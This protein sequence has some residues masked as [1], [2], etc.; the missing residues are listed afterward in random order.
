[1]FENLDVRSKLHGAAL[2]PVGFLSLLAVWSAAVAADPVPATIAAAGAFGTIVV[3]NLLARGLLRRL[4]ALEDAVDTLNE[5]D[6]PALFVDFDTL[7]APGQSPTIE[8][9]AGGGP[10]A[11]TADGPSDNEA[12][13]FFWP[14]DEL[15][16]VMRSIEAVPTTTRRLIGERRAQEE[17]ALQI[18]LGDVAT[19][20]GDLLDQQMAYI[21][22]LEDTERAPERLKHLFELDHI[23]NRLRR[24]AT[25][26]LVLSGTLPSRTES[27]PTPLATVA[28]VA[29]G[30]TEAYERIRLRSVDHLTMTAG[31]A[32][33]LAHLLA[34]L[35]DNALRHGGPGAV[36]L[37]AVATD[38]GGCRVSIID[39]GPGMSDRGLAEANA[40]LENPPPLDLTIGP[41]LGFLV[42]ARLATALGCRVRLGPN[43]DGG[44]DASVTVPPSLVIGPPPAVTGRPDRVATPSGA[45]DAAVDGLTD[46]DA[47]ADGLSFEDLAVDREAARLLG[48]DE[49]APEVEAEGSWFA[50]EV[51][52]DGAGRLS[53]RRKRRRHRNA[54]TDRPDGT[55][56]GGRSADD[57][58]DAGDGDPGKSAAPHNGVGGGGE[59]TLA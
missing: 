35:L 17:K 29:V 36:T 21:D 50:P 39:A 46:T 3:I 40:R 24:T 51:D 38:D 48:L 8:I 28:R 27:R 5:S 58:P 9:Q 16:A 12:A 10:D 15:T 54:D 19:R 37:D 32:P 22:W 57:R 47:D 45:L 42:V 33:A 13:S 44:I 2:V 26:I 31:A 23:T 56:G 11:V 59:P 53:R 18:I 34:E 52:N 30:E 49:A 1:M 55:D 6:L 4:A 20:H 7:I 14:D 41:S 43:G 25:S